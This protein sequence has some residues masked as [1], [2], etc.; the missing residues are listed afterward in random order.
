MLEKSQLITLNK[1]SLSELIFLLL[2]YYFFIFII[3][4]F[5]DFF[6]YEQCLVYK[7]IG[8]EDEKTIGDYGINKGAII[9]LI[10]PV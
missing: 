4:F 3:I 7:S 6:A 2:Y 9:D 10:T 5:L 8:P 1:I